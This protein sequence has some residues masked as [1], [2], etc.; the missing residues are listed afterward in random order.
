M[1]LHTFKAEIGFSALR[2]QYDE[3]DDAGRVLDTELGMI[4]GV[5]FKLGQSLSAW[6]WELLGSYHRGQVDYTGQTNL[7]N[8][9]NTR[10]G[11]TIS[12]VALRLGHWFDARYS[13]MPYAGFGYRRWDRNI[14]PGTVNGLFESYRWSYGWLGTKVTVLQQGQAQVVL[15]A[16]LLKPFAADMHV[17][18]M[19]AYNAAPVLQPES[20]LGLRMM[21][22]SKLALAQNMHVTLEP[23]FEYWSLGRSPT[24]TQ[25]GISVYEPTS[26]TNNAGFNLRFGREF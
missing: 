25:N 13:W 21:L 5:S 22:T 18:F 10:T 9:Y 3:F 8:P 20:R 26:K 4:P 14:L 1:E 7:G 12:D 16:G 24:V 23:Y 19:G 17:D 11:E 2:F 15:D 6:E